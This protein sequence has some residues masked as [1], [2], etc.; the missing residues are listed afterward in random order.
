MTSMQL[1]VESPKGSTSKFRNFSAGQLVL[2][3]TISIFLSATLLFS[4]QPMFSKL[5]LPLL[6]GSSNV[7][8]TAMVFFQS[9]LLLGYVYAHLISKY[10]TLLNQVLIHV[11]LLLVGLVFLPLSIAQDWVVPTTGTP[12]FWLLGLFSVSIGVPF[13]AISANAPLFQSWFS[14]TDHKQASDPYFLYAASNAGSL[15]TLCAYP[16]VIE[17]NFL[18]ETQTSS[19]TIGYAIL[20]ACILLCG[21][22]ALL[23]KAETQKDLSK[24][25]SVKASHST[26]SPKPIALKTALFWVFLAFIPSSL[27]LGVTSYMTNNIASAPF[28]WIIPLALYLLTFVIVFA[29]KPIVKFNQLQWL[30]PTVLI[31][32]IFFPIVKSVPHIISILV[33]LSIYFLVTLYCHSRLVESRP[34]AETLTQFYILMSLGGVLGGI[35]N[36]LLAPMIF[37]DI[38]EYLIVLWLAGCVMAFDKGGFKMPSKQSL[39]FIAAYWIAGVTTILTVLKMVENSYL[40]VL[41][42]VVS[43]G[44]LIMKRLK[45]SADSVLFHCSALIVLVFMSLSSEYVYKER[46]FYSTIKIN[47]EVKDGVKAHG[48]L[49]GDTIHNY[50]LLDEAHAT[51]PLAYYAEGNTF[52]QVVDAVRVQKP[53]MD[54]AVI[55]LGAGAMACFEQPGDNWTYFEIDPA[56][57]KMAKNPSLFSYLDRC[58]PNADIRIGD[59]RMAIQDLAKGSQDVIIV[60]A[61]S[62]DSIPVH[63]VTREALAIYRDYLKEDGV[64]FFHTS[65]R[66]MDVSSVVARLADDIGWDKQIVSVKALDS[67]PFKAFVNSSTGVIIGPKQVMA[68]LTK[69]KADWHEFE[70]HELVKLWTDDYSS[71]L[72]PIRAHH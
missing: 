47:T 62:S 19:W 48:F 38:Y 32:A 51:V 42:L 57:V 70:A 5:V 16:V 15:L 8:N 52:D 50:Q 69:D 61:F 24:T 3:F 60:D 34:H 66:V 55:G 17:P 63:L 13:F 29:R 36:A 7:W 45:N 25:A 43:F 14:K 37:N 58:S 26:L 20:I 12:I 33:T 23:N 49:H 10:F 28:L 72:G 65:N 21:A 11:T 64:I 31:V 40:V 71:I 9:M 22:F 56:V 41:V 6:G 30:F 53:T 67:H 44:F 18:L 2:V 68:S 59:A 54:I 27:M 1:A 46:S 39:A 35:F 4:V